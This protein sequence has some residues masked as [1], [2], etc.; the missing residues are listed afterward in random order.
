MTYQQWLKKVYEGS[1]KNSETILIN[2]I[3]GNFV[4]N[5]KS[6]SFNQ[7]EEITI[8]IWLSDNSDDKEFADIYNKNLPAENKIYFV[9]QYEYSIKKGPKKSTIPTI[10]DLKK[11]FPVKYEETENFLKLTVKIKDIRNLAATAKEKEELENNVKQELENA[12]NMVCEKEKKLIGFLNYSTNIVYEQLMKKIVTYQQEP[13]GQKYTISLPITKNISNDNA[14]MHKLLIESNFDPSAKIVYCALKNLIGET[15]CYPVNITALNKKLQDKFNGSDITI[16]M[17]EKEDRLDFELTNKYQILRDLMSDIEKKSKNKKTA[18]G[19]GEYYSNDKEGEK[20]WFQISENDTITIRKE[21]NITEFSGYFDDEPINYDAIFAQDDKEIDGMVEA[22]LDDLHRSY[23]NPFEDK[24]KLDFY[25]KKGY[26]TSAII[27]VRNVSTNPTMNGIILDIGNDKKFTD[28]YQNGICFDMPHCKEYVK[29]LENTGE[30]D[31]YDE[32]MCSLWEK[33]NEEIKDL[34]KLTL[35]KIQGGV[36]KTV[37]GLSIIIDNKLYYLSAEEY[38]RIWY[39]DKENRKAILIYTKEDEIEDRLKQR[40]ISN[41]DVIQHTIKLV[42]PALL[43]KE[44]YD[45]ESLEEIGIS[46]NDFICRLMM[47]DNEIINYIR[48][49]LTL[50]PNNKTFKKISSIK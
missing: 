36:D 20:Y 26:E 4:D 27:M 2:E 44:S 24:K 48:K 11:Y 12:Y 38:A 30:D 16:E 10:I 25:S 18:T 41:D 14:K 29:M 13:D 31:D 6:L 47:N 17:I 7:E 49:K 46:T 28:T 40:L 8:D 45:L 39:K 1:K 3:L 42:S 9:E 22:V 37:Q 21:T 15:E 43:E 19:I 23:F 35:T 5:S 34:I 50:A 33:A 32:E